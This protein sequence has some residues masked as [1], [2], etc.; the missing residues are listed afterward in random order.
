MKKIKPVYKHKLNNNDLFKFN[1]S[2]KIYKFKISGIKS[3][4]NIDLNI[5]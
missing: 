5:S 1:Y 3:L 4:K 2:K